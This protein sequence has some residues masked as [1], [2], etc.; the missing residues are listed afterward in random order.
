MAYIVAQT[1]DNQIVN[2]ALESESTTYYARR[3]DGIVYITEV[4]PNG[5]AIERFE[6]YGDDPV[7][8]FCNYIAPL[9]H[10]K[11]WVKN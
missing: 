5:Q 6:V 2:N 8:Y 4:A 9:R 10:I 3:I 1:Q 7:D 11:I